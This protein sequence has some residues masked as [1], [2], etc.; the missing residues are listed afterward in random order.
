MDSKDPRSQAPWGND[1]CLWVPCPPSPPPHAQDGA[2]LASISAWK[3]ESF[4]PSSCDFRLHI[5]SQGVY[6]RLRLQ[7]PGPLQPGDP[8]PEPI[9][10]QGIGSGPSFLLVWPT[11]GQPPQ[12][13]GVRHE[14]PAKEVRLQGRV[15][16]FRIGQ[17]PLPCPSDGPRPASPPRRARALAGRLLCPRD[18]FFTHLSVNEIALGLSGS[19]T[20]GRNDTL[21]AVQLGDKSPLCGACRSTPRSEPAFWWEAASGSSGRPRNQTEAGA[22]SQ[23]GRRRRPR[24]RG[25]GGS[26]GPPLSL[27]APLPPPFASGKDRISVPCL[28]ASRPHP[29]TPCNFLKGFTKTKRKQKTNRTKERQAAQDQSLSGCRQACGRPLPFWTRPCAPWPTG[30]RWAGS[31]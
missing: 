29:F 18:R 3:G 10:G 23:A 19:Y 5:L 13:H 4:L 7:A 20:S 8:G 25:G 24:D 21:Q 30:S 28:S 31:V 14:E 26:K 11:A 17:V 2:R 12:L 1:S 22:S 27:G 15:L 6:T 16:A 9:Q